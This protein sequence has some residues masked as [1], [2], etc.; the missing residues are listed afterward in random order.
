M[1]ITQRIESKIQENA[2]KDVESLFAK[3][4]ET[5]KGALG[6]A[7]SDSFTN[8]VDAEL[9]ALVEK[10]LKEPLMKYKT[11]VYNDRFF[12]QLESATELLA[13]FLGEAAK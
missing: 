7:Y 8:K 3:L 11:R 12:S 9:E 13:R 2:E 1:G 10:H 5:Y 4:K 6:I